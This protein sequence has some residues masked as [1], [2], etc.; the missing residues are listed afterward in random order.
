MPNFHPLA[1][2]RQQ[3]RLNKKTINQKDLAYRLGIEAAKMG[4]YERGQQIPDYDDAKVIGEYFDMPWHEVVE[5]C[6]A[7]R[8]RQKEF[9]HFF[10]QKKSEYISY[11][12]VCA[13]SDE[14]C[15]AR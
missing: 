10:S 7:F 5:I 13:T 9:Q 14:K 1:T 4:R 2:Y 15:G 12:H 8:D 11:S 3:K 6:V